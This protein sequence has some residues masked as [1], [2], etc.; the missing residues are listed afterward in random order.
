MVFYNRSMRVKWRV[1]HS[2]LVLTLAGETINGLPA[3][4]TVQRWSFLL[5]DSE[6]NPKLQ[7]T[8][9]S[10]WLRALEGRGCQWR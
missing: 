9:L 2:A 5:C 8:F 7:E 4:V 3:S 10:L 6:G 1:S